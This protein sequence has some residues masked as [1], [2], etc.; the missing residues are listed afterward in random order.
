MTRLTSIAAKLLV[1]LV[2]SGAVAAC[3]VAPDHQAVAATST[4]ANPEIHP[5]K[6]RLI[7]NDQVL[8]ATLEDSLPAREFIAQLPLTLQLE[9]YAATEKIAQLPR[10]LNVAGEP[11][12]ITPV[13]GDMAFYAPWGNLAIFHRPFGYSK[14][15]V[16]LGRIQGGLQLLRKTGAVEVR[17]ESF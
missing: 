5:M 13:A 10:S 15:L 16:R 4:G 3:S 11:E 7:I 8:S 6:I 17:I 2:A 1:L 14:G 9:D 12:G